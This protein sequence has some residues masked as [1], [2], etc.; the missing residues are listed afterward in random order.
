MRAKWTQIIDNNYQFN[1]QAAKLSIW[2]TKY[3]RGKM[4]E[5]KRKEEAAK[6][7]YRAITIRH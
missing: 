1:K 4:N 6:K 5:K 7:S 3:R 2:Q